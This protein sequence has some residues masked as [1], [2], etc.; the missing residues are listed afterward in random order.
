MKAYR[1]TG[2]FTIFKQNYMNREQP[3][4]IELVAKDE[5]DANHTVVSTI[6]SRHSTIRKNIHVKEIVHLKSNEVTNLVV[7]HQLGGK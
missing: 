2:T 5:A 7:K 3:F 1:A 6:G 4:S